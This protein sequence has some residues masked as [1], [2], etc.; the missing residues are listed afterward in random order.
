[1]PKLTPR[2][3]AYVRKHTRV[4]EPD[5]SEMEGELNIVPF[6]DITVN[7]I[8]VLLMLTTTLALYMQI[9]VRLPTTRRGGLGGGAKQEQS[10]N[11]TVVLTNRGII[12]TGSGGKLAPGCQ[13]TT[14]GDVITIPAAAGNDGK[15]RYDWKALRTCVETVHENFPDEDQV[16]FLADPP[17][18]FRHV[19]SAMDATREDDKGEP[20]FPRVQLSA[21][22]R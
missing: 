19:V 1:M 4:V 22:I 16:T 13:N 17:I 7:I 8:V 12:V 15:P 5:P 2:Q 9:G 14:I 20:L 11:L 10:L 18:E 3:R 21:G 6:L